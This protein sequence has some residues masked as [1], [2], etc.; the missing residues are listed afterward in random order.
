MSPHETNP[1]RAGTPPARAMSFGMICLRY[2]LPA[3]VIVAGLV[4]MALGSETELEGGAGIAGAGIAIFAMNW[5]IRAA[6]E[7]DRERTREQRAREYF[8][9][10]GRWPDEATR[11]ALDT[12]EARVPEAREQPTGARADS[13]QRSAGAATQRRIERAHRARTRGPR[14]S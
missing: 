10:H 9:E 5:L 14:H 2:V 12:P 6:T 11:A 3:S 1:E 7:G 8:A 13:T 4:V